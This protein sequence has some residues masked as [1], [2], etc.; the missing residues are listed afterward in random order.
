MHRRRLPATILQPPRKTGG[1]DLKQLA[2]RHAA[3]AYAGL[4]IMQ[5]VMLVARCAYS[6]RSETQ[7]NTSLAR[8]HMRV[9]VYLYQHWRTGQGAL[10]SCPPG[11]CSC[12]QCR[13]AQTRPPR[14][15]AQAG[16]RSRP[17]RATPL[18]SARPG[19]AQPLPRALVRNPCLVPAQ[20][21]KRHGCLDALQRPWSRVVNL[22]CLAPARRSP[23]QRRAVVRLQHCRP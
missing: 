6:E 21:G 19:C 16:P 4:I 15:H 20:E 8:P 7:L 3:D 2:Q 17:R 14:Q 10:Q 12:P 13:T 11:V 9:R 1:R 22:L 18:A 23:G 5:C